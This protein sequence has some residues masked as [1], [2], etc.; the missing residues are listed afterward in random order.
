MYMDVHA[1]QMFPSTA[2]VVASE[3]YAVEVAAMS[4][5][6]LQRIMSEHQRY[7]TGYQGTRAKLRATKL[8][9]LSLARHDLSEADLSGASLV[10]ADLRGI[11]LSHASLYCAD[12]SDCDL[13]YARLDHA[14][15]RGASFRGAN[16]A[17]AMMDFADLRAATMLYMGD[18]IRFQGNAHDEAPFGAVD[19]SHT[20][21]RHAS[22]RNA[23][24]D[25]ANFTDALLYGASFRGSRLRNACLRGA[26]LSDVELS[27]LNLPVK[28]LRHSLTNPTPAARGRAQALLVL[29]KAHH[30]WFISGGKKGGPAKLDGEDLRPLADAL[31][32]L[33][34][35][36]LQARNVVAVGVDFSGCAL[37]AARFE[38]C[39]LRGTNFYGADLSGTV[40]HHTKLGHAE[41]RN[42]LIRDLTLCTGQTVLFGVDIEE[43]PSKTAGRFS[44]ARVQ[45]SAFLAALSTE[46]GSC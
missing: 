34:L 7:L 15:L 23:K 35:A 33:C 39:D 24:L 16:L 32:G 17:H 25:N 38:D 44:N 46:Q 31:K 28:A 18:N 5:A 6:T 8:N 12:L 22:F 1:R 41:F 3:L 42:A 30:E 21:L 26:E 45:S 27:D 13:R 20:S 10:G 4:Q 43:R 37:Q 19:F 2:P 11:N 40:F 36:G 29:L 9:G 14:D